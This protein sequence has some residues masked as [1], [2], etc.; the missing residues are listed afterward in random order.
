MVMMLEL[1][2]TTYLLL[3][4][5]IPPEV[6]ADREV[7]RIQWQPYVLPPLHFPPQPGVPAWGTPPPCK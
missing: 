3:S 1:T 6:G 2:L 7:I 4:G 5:T